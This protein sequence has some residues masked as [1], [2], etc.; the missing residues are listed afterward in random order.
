MSRSCAVCGCVFEPRKAHYSLCPPCAKSMLAERAKVEKQRRL[1]NRKLETIDYELLADLSQLLFACR[2]EGHAR[3]ELVIEAG[4]D[5]CWWES[6]IFDYPTKAVQ[7]L[8]SPALDRALTEFAGIEREVKSWISRLSELEFAEEK[9]VP[10][11]VSEPEPAPQV[12]GIGWA[13][14]E[15][16]VE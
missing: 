15:Q 7:N 6:R 9:P 13:E 12:A 8:E 11:A 4:K 5:L 2:D 14:K 10:A 1:L 3:C 16:T